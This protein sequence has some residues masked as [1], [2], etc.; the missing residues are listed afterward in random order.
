MIDVQ[1]LTRV[2]GPVIGS[3][4]SLISLCLAALI[5]MKIV[6]VYLSQ[7]VLLI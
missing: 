1:W 3:K 5:M 4:R 6:I 7:E 2:T